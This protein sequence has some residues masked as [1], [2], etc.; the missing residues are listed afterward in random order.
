MPVTVGPGWSI[1]PGF[2]LGD[3]ALSTGGS[4]AL[5][6]TN[7]YLSATAAARPATLGASIFT[8]EMWVNF[9]A[10]P[11]AGSFANFCNQQGDFRFF[12][13]FDK[14]LSGWQGASTKWTTAAATINLNTWY[15][16]CIMRSDS[17]TCNI[18][19]NG[20]QQPK[21]LNTTTVVTYTQTGMLVGGESGNYRL[22]GLMTN[23]RMV[24]GTA[25]Y[26]VAGFTPP[27]SPLTNITNTQLLLSAASAGTFTNDSSTA[28]AGG[29][30]TVTNVNG[31]TYS[32]STPFV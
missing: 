28:N 9:T 31:A 16:I 13:Y 27:T 3:A 22:N 2:T 12:M 8:I 21:T 15:H 17:T 5:N 11:S 23:Y 25:V 24:V 4:I 32:A 14:T 20:V 10:F 7:Q 29:P 1:G 6:G 19:V 18:Y 30:Y 26:N